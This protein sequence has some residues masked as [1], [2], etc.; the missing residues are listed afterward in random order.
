MPESGKVELKS[1]AAVSKFDEVYEGSTPGKSPQD[2]DAVAGDLGVPG[3]EGE[4]LH[5][6]LRDP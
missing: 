3:H 1:V 2:R 4:V 6:R 5:P